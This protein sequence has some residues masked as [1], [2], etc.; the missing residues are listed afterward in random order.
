[1][2]TWLFLYPLL[3]ALF[4][5]VASANTKSV[6]IGIYDLPPH[7]ILSSQQA[8]RGAV[9]DFL[10]EQVFSGTNLVLEWHPSVFSRTLKDLEQSRIDMAV[11]VAK[12]PEREKAFSYSQYPIFTTRSGLVVNKSF[13]LKQVKD[14]SELRGLRL[15]HDL[16]SIV[17]Q[18][19]TN[20]AIRFEF[21][22]GEE[23]FPRNLHLLRGSR[24]QGFF[25][26]TWSN[27][28]YQLEVL[29]V[30]KEFSIIALPTQPLD[31]Y[32]VYRKGF[33]KE[34]IEL[35]DSAVKKK[36]AQY[37]EHLGHYFK[38]GEPSVDIRKPSSV[39]LGKN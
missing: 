26:P 19:L 29:G 3:M 15:G 37:L 30:D 14:L 4:C 32:V 12:T 7:M 6:T 10:K 27:G 25:V 34:V 16:G 1:M 39:E 17:P 18:D 24:T 2:K 13:K 8:P 23:Y 5:G 20:K 11:F 21:V 28:L 22:S 35:V 9:V 36:H 33:S 31:L 38:P